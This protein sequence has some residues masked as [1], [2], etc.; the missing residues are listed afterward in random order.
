MLIMLMNNVKSLITFQIIIFKI[1]FE[2]KLKKSSIQPCRSVVSY[3]EEFCSREL[4]LSTDGL[5]W[6]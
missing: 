5:F 3:I 6:T 1:Q 4:A 2:K